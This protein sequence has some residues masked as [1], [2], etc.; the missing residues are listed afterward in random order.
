MASAVLPCPVPATDLLT[1][2]RLRE[3]HNDVMEESGSS[4]RGHIFGAAALLNMQWKG[5]NRVAYGPV[6]SSI[7]WPSG[8]RTKTCQA[9]SGLIL[10]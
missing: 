3:E 4:F 7:T 5:P 10:R 6:K 1:G 9:P 8:S 2:F